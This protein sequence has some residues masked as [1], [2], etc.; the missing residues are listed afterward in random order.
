MYFFCN[1]AVRVTIQ[2]AEEQKT[3]EMRTLKVRSERKQ[4][5]IVC[6]VIFLLS[7]QFDIEM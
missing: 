1:L 5:K 3:L 7:C 4:I 2:V 6:V